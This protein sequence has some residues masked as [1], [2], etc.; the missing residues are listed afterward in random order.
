MCM[1]FGSCML[2]FRAALCCFEDAVW[3]LSIALTPP[4]LLLYHFTF[5]Y[6]SS[7]LFLYP[8]IFFCPY[9]S[10]LHAFIVAD[11]A[12]DIAL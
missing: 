3:M 11:I 1:F 6:S 4:L 5:L 2:H 10:P 12:F 8:L 7:C 9:I